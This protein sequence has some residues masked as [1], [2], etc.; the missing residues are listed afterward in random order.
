MSLHA[1][2]FY[3]IPEQTE[4]I[5]Q[6]AFPK[7]NPY[8][9]MRDAMGPIYTNPDFAHLFPKD[10]QPAE[11]PANLAL[12]TVMQFAEGLSDEQAATA[13][14]GRLDWKYALALELTDPGFDGSV[15]SEFRTRLIT[16]NAELLLFETMLTLFR[17]QGFI[18]V[19]GRQRTDSTHVLAAIHVLNRLECVGEA[20]RHALNVLATAAPDWLTAWV[21]AGWFDTYSRAFSDYHLPEGKDARYALAAQIGADGRAVLAQVFDPSAPAWLRDVPTVQ[22]LRQV[23]V[24]QFYAV[25]S[26]APM[27]WRVAEDLPPAPLLISSP[28]DPE[29]RYSKKRET[30]WVGYKV[31]VTETCDPDQPHLLTDVQTTL[32][33][34]P[35]HALTGVIQD[36]LAVRELQPGEHL[37]DAGYVTAE[38]LV[39]SQQEH[40][41]LIGPVP[42][43]PGWQAKAKEGF[44]A[45][46]FVID[47]EAQQATCPQGKTSVRWRPKQNAQGHGMVNIRFAASDCRDCPLRPKCV[48]SARER[49]LTVRDHDHYIALQAARQRQHTDLFKSLYRGRAGVEGTISQGTRTSDL[50]RSRYIGLAKTRLL[51][52]LI[53]TAL[54]FMRLAAWLAD[55]PH[56]Q[57]RRSAFAKLAPVAA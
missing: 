47:W 30:E 8:M 28:Y 25:A 42:P 11:A 9:A 49:S 38:R 27:R 12:A 54:N 41:D 4:Q 39:D 1:P 6:A 51:H 32:A 26:D 52:L 56:A 20:L 21:P 44:A 48:A 19:R 36:Q 46:C 31:H 10:G 37:V 15:L 2:L 45:S 35:D 33:T 24:Q 13:V 55:T 16:G 17:A 40:I 57:T 18:K 50:R 43:E 53:A 7:G 14:R 22:V 23:W 3:V 5:A 34:I 29:A